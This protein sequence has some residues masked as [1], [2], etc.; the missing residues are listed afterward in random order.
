MARGIDPL[1]AGP[2]KGV[3]SLQKLT[4]HYLARHLPKPTLRTGKWHEQLDENQIRYA[5]NDVQSAMHV[6]KR[7]REKLDE[8]IAGEGE[9]DNSVTTGM[10]HSSGEFAASERLKAWMGDLLVE[11]KEERERLEAERKAEGR[12]QAR[13][14]AETRREMTVTEKQAALKR[15]ADTFGK[16]SAGSSEDDNA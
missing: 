9:K 16:E 1:S 10:G 8:A 5:A 2:G 11:E 12:E 3:I 6:Y 14:E 4:A 7:L 13:K 15:E